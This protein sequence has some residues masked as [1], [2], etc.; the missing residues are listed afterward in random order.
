MVR[1]RHRAQRLANKGG[2]DELPAIG[3]NREG[4]GNEEPD[5][6]WCLDHGRVILAGVAGTTYFLDCPL[7]DLPV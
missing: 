1:D 3:K 7:A 2:R 6:Q 4:P 5:S